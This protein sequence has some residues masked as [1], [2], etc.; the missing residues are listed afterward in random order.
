MAPIK[1]P[2][3]VAPPPAPSGVNFGDLSMYAGG[4]TLPEGNY[5]FVFNAVMHAGFKQTT[6]APRLGIMVDAYP[7]DGGEPKPTFFSMGSGADKSFAPDPDTGKGLVPIP[8]APASTFNNQTNWALFLKSLYDCGLPAGV[9]TND[10]TVLDGIWVHTQNVPEPEERKGFG[11]RA[12]TG[13][14]ATTEPEKRGNQL[15]TVITEILEGGKPWEGGGGIPAEG[16]APVAA[17]AKAP[18]KPN[19]RPVSRPAAAPAPA[20]A[21]A[22]AADSTDEEAV[23]EAAING[24][25]AVLEKAPNGVTKLLLRTGTFKAVSAAVSAEMASAVISNYVE[26]EANLTAIL[27]QLGYA[28]V[29]G[30]IKPAA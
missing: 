17:P 16:A 27:G 26:N 3:A 11:T 14:A 25:S 5:A 8:G 2:A 19:L 22:T 7:L 20:P 10:L 28:L 30:Q 24:M 1:R 18:A 29:G 23:Q 13:E 15:T 9:F 12:A 6:L 21:A 4:F